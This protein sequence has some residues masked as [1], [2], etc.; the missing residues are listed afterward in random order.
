MKNYTIIILFILLLSATIGCSLDPA[1]SDPTGWV[2]EGTITVPNSS[3]WTFLKLGVFSGGTAGTTPYLDS[4]DDSNGV[5]MYRVV[6][7]NLNDES[8]VEVAA[9]STT[10]YTISDTTGTSSSYSFELPP[11]L[12]VEDEEYILAAWYDGDADGNLD[13]K[14]ADPFLKADI[15]KL[16]EFNRLPTKETLDGDDN[17]TTIVIENFEESLDPT[18][19]LPT[20][21]YKYVGY[22][23]GSYT[24]WIEITTDADSSGF[25][26]NITANTGW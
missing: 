22:D 1:G 4:D 23:G 11:V 17:P 16:G 3:Y 10:S 20:G 15:V 5:S 26:F 8:D 19:L 9:M 14:D 6:Y 13:L 12:P 24:E 2:V 21:N 18:T 25:N 7:A